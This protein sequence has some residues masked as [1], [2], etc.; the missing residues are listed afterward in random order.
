MTGHP[1]HP[2][3]AA[4]LLAAAMAIFFVLAAVGVLR[5]GLAAW[6]FRQGALPAWAG[7]ATYF[8]GQAVRN[9]AHARAVLRS[10]VAANPRA[11]SAWISLGLAAEDARDAP[12]AARDFAAAAQVDHLYLPAWSAA[13]FFFRRGDPAR[14]WQEAARAAA[15]APG[16]LAPLVDLADRME[17]AAPVAIAR[18]SPTRPLERAYLDFLIGKQR[19]DSAQSIAWEIAAHHDP[20]DGARLLDL[21]DRLLAAGREDAALALC[22]GMYMHACPAPDSGSPSVLSNGGLDAAP[23]G[24]AFDWR[25]PASPGVRV[26]WQSGQLEF[27]LAASAPAPCAL[28]E[29]PVRLLP[30]RYR[31]R[32]EYRI[33]GTA[34]RWVVDQPAAGEQTSPLYAGNAREWSHAEWRFSASRAGLARLRLICGREPGSVRGAGAVGARAV[35]LEVL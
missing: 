33:E 10:A 20:S 16:D 11:S 15:L 14:F 22:T 3:P 32:F 8:E 5:L 19:W 28:L 4:R 27:R 31:L 12:E 30:R 17:P 26:Q 21:V 34:V 18:L 1:H 7:N 24:H 29:Q 25:L 6:Q 35:S 9:P 2:A 13:N 23:S